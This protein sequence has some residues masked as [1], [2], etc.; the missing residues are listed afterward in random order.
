ML[1]TCL[2]ASCPPHQVLRPFLGSRLR[3]SLRQPSRRLGK[4]EHLHLCSVFLHQVPAEHQ[5]QNNNHNQVLRRT[6]KAN[7]LLGAMAE[8]S[9][10]VAAETH[11]PMQTIHPANQ[12]EKTCEGPVPEEAAAAHLMTVMVV[13]EAVIVAVIHRLTLR[14][15]PTVKPSTI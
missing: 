13:V 7:A 9:P 14:D 11:L 5:D 10:L 2:Q 3:P 12:V 1:H 6:I 4:Q 15:Q 8:K